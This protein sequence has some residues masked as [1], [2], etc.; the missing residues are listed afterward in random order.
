MIITTRKL[1]D[2]DASPHH[3][4]YKKNSDFNYK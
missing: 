4:N 3:N 2:R 1:Q